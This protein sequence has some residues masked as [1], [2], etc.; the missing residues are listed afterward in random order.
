MLRLLGT[1]IE[2]ATYIE[3][4][5]RDTDDSLLV[6]LVT[7][8]LDDQTPFRTHGHTIRVSATSG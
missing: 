8:L 2:C 7:G 4:K 6:D 5:H 3:I 1:V